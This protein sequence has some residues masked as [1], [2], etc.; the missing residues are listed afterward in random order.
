MVDTTNGDEVRP[1]AG[2]SAAADAAWTPVTRSSTYELVIDAI[3]DQIMS[4][5]LAVG[6]LLPPERELAARLRVSRAGVREAIRVL[7]AYGVLRSEVGSGRGAGTFVAAMP[8]AAL[9]RFL[10]LH[11][12][13]SNFGRHEV[14]ET[15][16]LLEQASASLAAERAD[17]DALAELE[18][19]LRVMDDPGV[20][21]EDFNDA[22]TAFHLA[23][24]QAGGNALFSAMTGA[25]RASLRAPI[26]D[27]LTEVA[28]WEEIAD[29][30]RAQH[31]EIL[32]AISEGRAEEAA[33]LTAAHI[34]H[35][36]AALPELGTDRAGS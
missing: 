13:L 30:L 21:R 7:Q 22:D 1:Q 2:R 31:H 12:A 36:V 26:L 14:I 8:S 17:A 5:A 11:V 3:E 35:A 15:R 24:A 28:R 19:L 18:R 23:I 27:A 9:E 32:R 25:I 16:I 6:D 29:S 34:R 20:S 10:R 33:E 4:G